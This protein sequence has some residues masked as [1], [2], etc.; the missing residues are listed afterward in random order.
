MEESNL[1]KYID[2]IKN[3]N[4]TVGVFSVG[5][6]IY[7]PQFPGLKE[8][9]DKHFYSFC[10]KL[11]RE[12]TSNIIPFNKMCDR[13]LISTE[14]GHFFAQNELDL[15]ICYISTYSPSSNAISVIQKLIEVPV[16]LVSL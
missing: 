8:K 6:Y 3:S 15:L 12:S 4:S 14:A 16:I 11:K 9:L 1:K 2:S 13:Y 7:W 10:K 5:H